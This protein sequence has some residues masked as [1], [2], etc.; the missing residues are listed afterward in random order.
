MFTVIAFDISDDRTRY[1]AVKLLR[2]YAVRVQK[3]VFEA[4]RLKRRAFERL[5]GDLERLV[6][7]RT[8]KIRF[9]FL[10]GGC[11]ERVEISGRG[12]LASDPGYRIL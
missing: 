6:D 2:K 8:D 1:R 11:I 10:C 5:R 7:L 3:S 12:K 4:P 9:Y